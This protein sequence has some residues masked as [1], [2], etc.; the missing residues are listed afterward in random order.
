MAQP[1][2]HDSLDTIHSTLDSTHT[3]SFEHQDQSVDMPELPTPSEVRAKHNGNSF[4]TV[5]FP[6]RELFVKYGPPHKASIDEA[7]TLQALRQ[8][9]PNNEVPI[10][11][12]RGWRTEEGINYIY[13]SLIP[14]STLESVWSTLSVSEKDRIATQVKQ[15]VAS[16]RSL[17][18]QP[19]NRFIGVFF[20]C[21]DEQKC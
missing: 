19:E 7:Q 17:G 6:D 21:K 12:L 16:L 9:F 13:M 14:G 5:S 15:I 3:S 11:Q 10:P 20:Q 8:A 18:Q 2:R 4:G 1:S